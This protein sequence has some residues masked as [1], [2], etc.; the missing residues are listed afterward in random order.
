[1]FSFSAP[2]L[3]TALPQ[4]AVDDGQIQTLQVE[5][6]VEELVPAVATEVTVNV[7]GKGDD[8]APVDPNKV[9]IWAKK[10]TI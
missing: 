2:E 1:M 8:D 3:R 7:N 6:A 4:A 10:R 5:T 9:K